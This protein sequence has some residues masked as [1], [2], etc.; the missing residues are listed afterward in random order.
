M[1]LLGVN[2]LRLSCA[3][4]FRDWC[5]GAGAVTVVEK[6][7]ERREPGESVLVLQRSEDRLRISSITIDLPEFGAEIVRRQP[8][9]VVQMRVRREQLVDCVQECLRP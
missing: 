7:S 8:P 6:R 4:P 1:L 3:D 2:L 9:L 5:L